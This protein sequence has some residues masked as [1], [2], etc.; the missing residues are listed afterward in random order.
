[1]DLWRQAPSLEGPALSPARHPQRRHY[2]H[3][4]QT[5]AYL[6]LDQSNGGIIRNLGDAGIAVQAV[7]P[8]ST[9]QRVF[10]RFDLANPK[11][12][13]EGTGR[14]AWADP[15][16]Q[17]GI[18]FLSLSHRSRRG[19][20]EWIFIQ[21]LTAALQSAEG[22]TFVDGKGGEAAEL[23]FSSASRPAIRLPA[24]RVAAEARD[25]ESDAGQRSVHLAWLPFSISASALSRLVDGLILTSAVLLFAVI[26][27]AM[28]G[29]VPAW[30][31]LLLLG[32]GVAGVF[33]IVYRFLF[34]FWIGGTPGHFLARLTS[35]ALD[36]MN[37]Q[38]E[39]RPRF[40]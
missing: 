40:R 21:L 36:G 6:N 27:M 19:L 32:L 12:R 18:E 5:L 7:A 33:T 29:A 3:Q 16:G 9:D 14:V 20:K 15:V 1:M 23:L 8:L 17:A 37:L 28:I 2:R 31:I 4:I 38:A 30:P 34:L 22:L 35:N 39:E 26:G 11:V 24:S 13:I 10:L 25:E